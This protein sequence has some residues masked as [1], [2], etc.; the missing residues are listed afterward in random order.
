MH[1]GK[2]RAI[3]H[4]AMEGKGVPPS[5]DNRNGGSGFDSTARDGSSWRSVSGGQTLAVVDCGAA[6]C[7]GGCLTSVGEQGSRPV[8]R[9]AGVE[10]SAARISSAENRVERGAANASAEA[11]AALSAAGAQLGRA[12]KLHS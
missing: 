3:E 11:S 10:N 6:G 7:D 4:T 12:G 9:S 5:A 2:P 1:Q 8:V